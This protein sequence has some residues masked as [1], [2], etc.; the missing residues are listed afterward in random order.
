MRTL[1]RSDLKDDYLRKYAS[2]NPHPEHVRDVLFQ[3]HPFFDPRDLV[4]VKYEMLRRVIIDGHSVE[5]ATAAFGFSRVR[6]YQLRKCLATEGL[7]GLLPQSKG[8]RRASKLSNEVVTFILQTMQAE[9]ELRMTELPMRVAQRFG[10][11]VH[12]RSIERVVARSQK[13]VCPKLVCR[14]YPFQQQSGPG[15][16][17]AGDTKPCAVRCCKATTPLLKNT[18]R[19][20]RRPGAVPAMEV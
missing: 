20:S 15:S 4:Q 18:V 16:I 12:L 17:A 8:P 14:T 19:V 7:V 9:P 2:L 3:T 6:W 5:A 13:K 11:S 1:A 10:L